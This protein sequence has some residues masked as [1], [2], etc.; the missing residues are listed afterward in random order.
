MRSSDI[1]PSKKDRVPVQ[2]LSKK[3]EKPSEVRSSGHASA[4]EIHLV[5]QPV[6]SMCMARLCLTPQNHM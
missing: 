2:M 3:S 4:G 1:N 6:R 5:Q